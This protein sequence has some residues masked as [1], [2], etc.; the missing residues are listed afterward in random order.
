MSLYR[1][2]SGLPMPGQPL[3]ANDGRGGGADVTLANPELAG[4][5]VSA[6][7]NDV[8][9]HPLDSIH[10]D[11]VLE[12]FRTLPHHIS[13]YSDRDHALLA[14]RLIVR[15]TRVPWSKY[16]QLSGELGYAERWERKIP[17]LAAMQFGKSVI[18]ISNPSL[19]VDVSRF[20]EDNCDGVDN[21]SAL[22]MMFGSCI[23]ALPQERHVPTIKALLSSM[24]RHD[25]LSDVA[26]LPGRLQKMKAASSAIRT[27]SRKQFGEVYR[28]MREVAKE[29]RTG[30][31][32]ILG[33]NDLYYSE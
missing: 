29:T 27:L 18:A 31:S 26:K 21:K 24:M 9:A 6:A 5:G 33:I 20:L 17:P 13:S 32:F 30:E 4:T 8:V 19:V 22:L 11:T 28:S 23:A 14:K 25:E 16:P 2:Q 15:A 10:I 7:G 3:W 1:L 12:F